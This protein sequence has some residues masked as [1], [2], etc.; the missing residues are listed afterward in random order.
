MAL[1]KKTLY[2]LHFSLKGQHIQHIPTLSHCKGE[3]LEPQQ[4]IDSWALH[5]FTLFTTLTFYSITHIQFFSSDANV[6]QLQLRYTYHAIVI[7]YAI[8]FSFMIQ[9]LDSTQDLQNLLQ[10]QLV[11]DFCLLT[12]Q[13]LL[14]YY[15]IKV[16]T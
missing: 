10:S 11:L 6:F 3:R 16:F 7:S 2:L 5:L 4:N 14:F 8:I 1:T 9:P 13:P 15:K 12:V